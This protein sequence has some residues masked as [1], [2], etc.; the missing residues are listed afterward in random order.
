[1]IPEEMKLPP[2]EDIPQEIVDEISEDKF[3]RQ[4]GEYE[5]I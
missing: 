4:E 2:K 3:K 1:M 5:W